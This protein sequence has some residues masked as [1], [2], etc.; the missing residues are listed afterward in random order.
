MSDFLEPKFRAA[1]GVDVNVQ[2]C[3]PSTSPKTILRAVGCYQIPVLPKQVAVAEKALPLKTV[4]QYSPPPSRI[5]ESDERRIMRKIEEL[6]KNE[7]RIVEVE[8]ENRV[9][10]RMVARRQVENDALKAK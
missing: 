3:G 1:D 4:H 7:A 8:E 5:S 6:L 9:L 2:S 10:A